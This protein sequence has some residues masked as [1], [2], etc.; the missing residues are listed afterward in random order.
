MPS[1]AR[2]LSEAAFDKLSNGRNMDEIQ[3]LLIAMQMSDTHS[4]ATPAD[5][6]PGDKVIIPPPPAPAGKQRMASRVRVPS[7]SALTGSSA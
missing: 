2:F 4:V 3:R 7:M 5:W 1:L 6:Q